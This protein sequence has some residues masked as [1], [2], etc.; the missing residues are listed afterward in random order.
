MRKAQSARTKQKM[1]KR[2][3]AK[4]TSNG[5]ASAAAK[6]KPEGTER[7]RDVARDGRVVQDLLPSER[8]RARRPA[9]R[10]PPQ[11]RGLKRSGLELEARACVRFRLL[12]H[13]VAVAQLRPPTGRA[14]DG[15]HSQRR[16]PKRR[17]LQRAPRSDDCR[18]TRAPLQVRERAGVGE[19]MEGPE[20]CVFG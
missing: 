2:P 18:A 12:Q 11:P 19:H 16:E 8:S 7:A 3:S 4:M 10:N 9:H 6:A 13:R 5:V 1:R 20:G 17:G 14:F 15:H